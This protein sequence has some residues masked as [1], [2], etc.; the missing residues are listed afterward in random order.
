MGQLQGSIMIDL[1]RACTQEGYKVV[2]L[3][4]GL[5][6]SLSCSDFWRLPVDLG[7]NLFRMTI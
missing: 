7:I 1:Q 6:V 3:S 2:I 5:S 4:V